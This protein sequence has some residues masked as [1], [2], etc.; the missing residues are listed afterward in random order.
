MENDIYK[1]Y[2]NSI[3]IAFQWKYTTSKQSRNKIQIVFRNM[4]FFLTLKEIKQFYKNV[5]EAKET[6]QCTCCNND[7]ETRSILVK[8]PSEKVDI[9]VNK[10]ELMEVEDLIRGTLFQLNLDDYLNSICKN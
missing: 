9:A 2:H 7:T 10:K 8:T 3:G 6:K 1:I 5:F 4:G